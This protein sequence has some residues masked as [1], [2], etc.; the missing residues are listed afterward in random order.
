MVFITD[1]CADLSPE[2]CKRYQIRIIPLHSYIDGTEIKESFTAEADYKRFYDAMRKGAKTSTSQINPDEFIT[3]FRAILE[4][5][6]DVFY[7]AF[8]SAL[9]AT[10]AGAVVAAEQLRGE[11]PDRKIV[12]VDSLCASLGH[13]LIVV[14][15]A[16]K[17]QQGAS[18]EEMA[19]FVKNTRLHVNH[20]FTVDDL[21]YLRRGGRISGLAA[22]MGSL[23]SIKPVLHV[24]NE[25]KLIPYEKVKGRKRS[26]RQLFKHFQDMVEHPSGQV[27]AISHCD[28]IEDAAELAEMIRSQYDVKEILINHIG[29]VVGAH[30]GPGTL[31]LFFTGRLREDF[32]K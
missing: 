17:M 20:W 24:N 11:F 19:E 6:E 22:V 27:I 9:S 28:C 7:L 18:P 21:A 23:L 14:L 12:V 1:S 16:E 26:V 29:P 2:V 3:F 5:G 15:T 31:A 8:S 25:G 30:S 13:G 10:Y 32:E 4:E